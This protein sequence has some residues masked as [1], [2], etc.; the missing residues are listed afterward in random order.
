MRQGRLFLL[1]GWTVIKMT[2]GSNLN[3]L[4]VTTQ[5]NEP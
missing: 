3:G 2:V 4:R 5:E 1:E